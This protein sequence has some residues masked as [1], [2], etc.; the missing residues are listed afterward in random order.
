MSLIIPVVYSALVR[1]KFLGKIKVA[2]LATN[3]GELMNTNVGDTVSFPKFK[4]IGDA[5][6]VVKG[7]AST[8]T[9]LEQDESTAKI[10]MIDKIIRIFDMDNLT[11]LGNHVE[12][13][14]KQ[15]AIVFA[16]KLDSDLVEEAKTSSLKKATASANA[17][18]ATELNSALALFGDEQDVEDMSGIVVHSLVASSF[19]AM[20]EFVSNRTDTVQGNGIVT[21]GCIGFFRGIPV[22]M[23]DHGT[24]DSVAVECVTLIIKKDALAYMEKRAINIVEEVESKLH[25]SD[26]VGDYIYSV[27]LINDAGVVVVR[28]TIV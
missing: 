3:L 10:K 8:I 20:T 28:K 4:T 19:Y 5:D 12:E 21:G 13:A 6:E 16:R 17:I 2:T 25:A 9:S 24:Y 23:S 18:T 7:T 14:S 22:F 27:K 11:S 26:V 15:Q 1:E